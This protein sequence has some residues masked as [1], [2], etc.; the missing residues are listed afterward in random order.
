MLS[1]RQIVNPPIDSS[2]CNGISTP[3]STST[4]CF[5]E[6]APNGKIYFGHC[7]LCNLSVINSPDSLDTLCNME[8]NTFYLPSPNAGLPPYHP[9]YR[10]GPLV[11]SVC[12]TLS[13]GVEEWQSSHV[14]IFPNPTQHSI[15]VRLGRTCEEIQCKFYNMQGQL[16][17]Q[18]KRNFGNAF[19]LDF[20]K[21]SKGLYL[22]EIL[23]NEGRVVKKVVVG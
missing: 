7:Y 22:L 11:G 21:L 5:P 6:L 1:S 23:C 20:P 13:V 9:N 17:F 12:D 14:L 15:N 19:T 3:L 2:C 10:L 4:A 8:F 18:E 16:L